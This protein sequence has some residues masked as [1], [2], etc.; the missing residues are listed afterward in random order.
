MASNIEQFAQQVGKDIKGSIQKLSE[1][2]K[3][4]STLSNPLVKSYLL[5]WGANM[6]AGYN[7]SI[8]SRN[9]SVKNGIGIIH[10][11]FIAAVAKGIFI[12]ATLPAESP[13]FESICDVNIISGGH[14]WISAGQREIYA[15]GIKTDT[16]IIVD[17]IGFVK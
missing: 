4:V 14:I 10:L 8:S 11:D 3:K 13:T 6:S 15:A 9:L 2:E 5:M 7:N 17:I 16:R 1:I 12:V